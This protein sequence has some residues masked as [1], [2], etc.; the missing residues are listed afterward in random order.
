MVVSGTRSRVWES[1]GDD[2]CLD[3][4]QVHVWRTCLDRAHDQVDAL[5]GSLSA[6]ERARAGRLRTDEQRSRFTC[7]R[8]TLRT[9]VARYLHLEPG[10]VP[11]RRDEGG[12]PFIADSTLSFNLTHAGSLGLFAFTLERR[13]GIDVESAARQVASDRIAERFLCESEASQLRSLQPAQVRH[14]AFMRCWTRKEAYLKATGEG[15]SAGALSRFEVSVNPRQ[16]ARLV[17]ID[18]AQDG[19]ERWRLED[20][21]LSDTDFVGAVCVEGRDWDMRCL[22]FE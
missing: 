11:L 21:P 9:L 4:T 2:A 5:S 22:Q 12:K 14:Q 8:A 18:G 20:L 6:D 19:V 10:Q 13:V 15:I 16:A 1:A 17:G 3:T 7:G